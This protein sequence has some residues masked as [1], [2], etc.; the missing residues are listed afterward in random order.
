MSHRRT[1][2][3][4]WDVGHD[5]NSPALRNLPLWIRHGTVGGG[6][7]RAASPEGGGRHTGRGTK[8]LCTMRTRCCCRCPQV[9]RGPGQTAAPLS[10]ARTTRETIGNRRATAG[11]SLV[12]NELPENTFPPLPPPGR[13]EGIGGGGGFWMAW[14]GPS[15]PAPCSP[16]PCSRS[17][18]L[19]EGCPSPD[20]GESMV[21]SAVWSSFA[22]WSRFLRR[23]NLRRLGT[24]AC[25]GVPD[26]RQRLGAP[27]Q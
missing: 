6:A 23:G 27:L 26:G 3:L 17:G 11:S 9:S 4:V 15:V 21:V 5:S 14:P 2:L 25:D 12:A 20:D 8:A 18:L 7:T 1:A 10:L 22:P 16:C 13:E 19:S 24:G